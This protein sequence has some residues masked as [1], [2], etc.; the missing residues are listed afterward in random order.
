MNHDLQHENTQPQ[1]CEQTKTTKHLFAFLSACKCN[2]FS[3]VVRLRNEKENLMKM[4]VFFSEFAGH[5]PNF[6]DNN[7]FFSLSLFS[8]FKI[9]TNGKKLITCKIRPLIAAYT[10]P[11]TK[12]NYRRGLKFQQLERKRHST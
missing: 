6:R 10:T 4:K 2:L 12:H 7:N 8:F 9:I 5:H 3:N 11:Y 1:K